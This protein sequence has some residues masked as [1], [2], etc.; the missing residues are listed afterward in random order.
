M[1]HKLA[2]YRGVLNQDF[3]EYDIADGLPK[4]R[5]HKQGSS[6]MIVSGGDQAELREVLAARGIA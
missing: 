4:L 3:L 1:K 2:G 5:E 6:W